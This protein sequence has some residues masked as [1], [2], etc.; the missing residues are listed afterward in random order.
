MFRAAVL[1]VVLMLAGGPNA[2]LLCAVWCHPEEAKSSA[3][4][5]Q[6]AITPPSVT[7]ED[8][9]GTVAGTFT[10]L[11][12]DEV[13][14]RQPVPQTAAFAPEVALASSR[15]APR[16]SRPFTALGLPLPPILFALRL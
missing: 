2:T 12:R 11:V 9:C 4:Q 8:S 6:D 13:K 15:M 10:A 7:R 14:G 16:S 1:V 5:H 3:C